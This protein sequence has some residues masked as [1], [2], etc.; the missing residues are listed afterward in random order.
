MQDIL[1]HLTVLTA[2]ADTGGGVSQA[3]GTAQKKLGDVAQPQP[4]DPTSENVS[5][6]GHNHL[7]A[8]IEAELPVALPGEVLKVGKA[9]L[10]EVAQTTKK[11]AQ[12]DGPDTF[13]GA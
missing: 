2:A 11:P 9:N 3:N 7:A 10:L 12:D 4:T 1:D 6:V 8:A 13:E 5:H